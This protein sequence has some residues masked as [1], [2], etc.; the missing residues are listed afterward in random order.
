MERINK[1]LSSKKYK[2]YLK[3]VE[4]LEKDRIF[5]KHNMEHFLDTARIAYIMCLEQGIKID[6]EV[7]YA[8]GFLHDIGRWMQ[9]EMGIPHD[10]ASASIAKELL[11]E[12]GFNEEEIGIIISAILS[13]RKDDGQGLSSIFYKAD[14]MSRLC[15]KCDAQEECNWS[16][17]KKNLNLKL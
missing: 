9:Y 6:K 1:L 16:D 8:F 14:K 4:V 10:E 15:F 11:N 17:T 13:H 2:E 3:K 12:T 7:I 5:C